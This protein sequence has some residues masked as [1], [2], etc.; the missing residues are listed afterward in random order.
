MY[1]D[2]FELVPDNDRPRKDC[3]DCLNCSH[4]VAVSV[5]STHQP[6]IKAFSEGKEVQYKANGRWY[7]AEDIAFFGGGQEFRIKPEPK[8]RP[9]K[10]AKE[11]WQEMLKHQPFGWIKDRDDN[12]TFIGSIN[13]D[14]SV[15][16][17]NSEILFLKDIFEDFTF[18]DGISFGVKVEE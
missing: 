3:Y 8:Y 10:D 15:C 6:I 12:K 4:L 11:C 2:V 7:L 14:N 18:I 1:I 9:F 13:S 17:C 16:M 5:D